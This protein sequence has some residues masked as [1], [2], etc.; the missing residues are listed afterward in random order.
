[1]FFIKNVLLI[2]QENKSPNK[3]KDK[4]EI[5]EEEIKDPEQIKFE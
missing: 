4:K 3:K 1:M 2:I 5:I